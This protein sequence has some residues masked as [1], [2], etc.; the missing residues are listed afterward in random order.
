[1]KKSTLFFLGF[2]LLAFVVAFGYFFSEWMF[3]RNYLAANNNGDKAN[4]FYEDEHECPF[5]QDDVDDLSAEI[6]RL[7]NLNK[8]LA[9]Q[10]DDYE[11]LTNRLNESVAGT[12]YCCT[13]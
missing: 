7:E 5:T 13:I 4:C 3:Q 12:I 1:M 6:D 2:M 9:D 10:L 8:Q 11:D